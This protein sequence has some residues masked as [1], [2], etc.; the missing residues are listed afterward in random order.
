VCCSS[1]TLPPNADGTCQTRTIV[2]GDSCSTL[3]AKCGITPAQFTTLNPS[4]TLCSTLA[5]G[6]I[7][8]CGR[9][10]L[11]DITPKPNSDGSCFVYQTKKD[12]SCSAIAASRGLTVAKVEE[13]NKN[14]RGW[15]GCELLWV[16]V[17][18]CLSTGSPPMPAPVSNA[19]CGPTVPGTQKPTSLTNLAGL[20]P[21]PLKVCCNIWGQCGI[22]ANFCVISKSTTGAP[23]TAAPGSNGCI[24][25]CG[26]DIVSSSPP[27]TKIKVT[28][29]ESWNW[30]RPCLHMHVDSIN[31]ATYTH[32]HFAFGNITSN[33]QV[34]VSGAQD[35][36]DRFKKMTG[37]KKIIS[38]GGWAFSTEPGIFKIL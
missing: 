25:S 35:E 24:A 34:D 19:V 9:G 27:A 32:I 4:T 10:N 26:M 2:S 33:F 28:Y 29:F 6:G 15:N 5:P 21:C 11:P 7:V 16:G 37:I 23:G 38:F 12:D 14:T 1:G 3:A 30:G 22:T 13:F 18:M 8:C 31:T 17:N 20:N 36:F